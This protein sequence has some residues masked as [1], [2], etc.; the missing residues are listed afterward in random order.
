MKDNVWERNLKEVREWA[1]Q[2]I[3]RGEFRQK[4]ASAKALKWE[5]KQQKGP[6]GRSKE[7][8]NNL[9]HSHGALTDPSRIKIPDLRN[10]NIFNSASCFFPFNIILW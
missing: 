3:E 10:T 2:I 6:P 8:N 1:I 7:R 9:I 5:Q 4:T